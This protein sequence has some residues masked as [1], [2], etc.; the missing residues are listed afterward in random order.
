M[1]NVG[2]IMTR[3]LSSYVRTPSGYLIAAAVL[4]LEAL[5]FNGFALTD[6]NGQGRLSSDVLAMFFYVA[7]IM[8]IGAASLF[9]VRLLAEDRSN[10]TDVLLATSPVRESEVVL[11]KY[12]AA[13]L[14]LS[15]ITLLSIYMPMLI[16]VHGKVSWGHILAGYLGLILLG[17]AV[18][19]IGMFVSSLMPHPLLTPFLTITIVVMLEVCWLVAGVADPPFDEILQNLT[20]H[21][22]HFSR[23]FQGGILRLSDVVFYVSVAYVTL[24]GAIKTMQSRRWR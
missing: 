5:F 17:G 10:G 3:E 23:G 6:P 9:S 7:A 20:L 8:T 24:L 18:L 16:L 19:G 2:L 22:K 15:V 1:R 12:F 11:G 4:F 21:T 14:F 13:L